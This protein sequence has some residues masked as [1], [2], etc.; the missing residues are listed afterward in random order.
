MVNEINICDPTN[1]FSC[2]LRIFSPCIPDLFDTISSVVF[3]GFVWLSVGRQRAKGKIVISGL[4]THM[5]ICCPGE[6]HRWKPKI[7]MFLSNLLALWF[8]SEPQRRVMCKNKGW[9]TW[10]LNCYL[11]LSYHFLIVLPCNHLCISVMSAFFLVSPSPQIC[12]IRLLVVGV[13]Q[14]PHD[15]NCIRFVISGEDRH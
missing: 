3:S 10:C 4:V 6:A 5:S 14:E 2:S 8:L 13:F 7:F 9:L 1:N 11:V 15:I 12:L